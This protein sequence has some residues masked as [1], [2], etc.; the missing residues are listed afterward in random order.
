MTD[1]ELFNKAIDVFNKSCKKEG[2]SSKSNAGKNETKDKK[3]CLHLNI[4]NER[5]ANVCIDCGEE[6]RENLEHE[7]EWRYYGQ[8]DNKYTS[9]LL[10]TSPSP[11]D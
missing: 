9:C 1:F 7:K 10:Y 2:V 4:E 8:S 11:R 3:K 6:I 5:G